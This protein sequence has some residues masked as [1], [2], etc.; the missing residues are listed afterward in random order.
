MPVAVLKLPVVLL[1]S[2]EIERSKTSGGVAL[3]G[4]AVERSVTIGRVVVAGDVAGERI[5]ASGTIEKPAGVAKERINAS[6]G[7]EAAI[8]IAIQGS[9]TCRRILVAGREVVKRLETSAGVPDPSGAAQE[10]VG[11]LSGI[12]AG[13]A[14]VR[15]RDDCSR[16]WQKAKAGKRHR[17]DNKGCEAFGFN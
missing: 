7:V 10:S 13:V 2:V 11:S 12:A 4:V 14:A 6:G 16:F 9:E 3:G 17:Q 1:E 15:R 5:R 8:D